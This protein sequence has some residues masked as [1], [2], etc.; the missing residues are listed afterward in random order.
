MRDSISL[1]YSIETE[2]YAD[3]LFLLKGREQEW[4]D[5][6]PM[7][8]IDIFE[9]Y[10]FRDSFTGKSKKNGFVLLDYISKISTMWCSHYWENMLQMSM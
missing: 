3:K 5:V 4:N 7:L 9:N 10:I 2:R 8:D 1:I 6:C